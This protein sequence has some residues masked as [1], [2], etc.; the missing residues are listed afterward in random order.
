VGAESIV[1]H[2]DVGRLLPLALALPLGCTA[3]TDAGK[4]DDPADTGAGAC[5]LADVD[6]VGMFLHAIDGGASD[7]EREAIADFAESARALPG[8]WR[9]EIRLAYS[10]DA[11]EFTAVDGTVLEHAAVPEILRTDDGKYL[12]YYV[13]GDLDR[14]VSIADE[15][16]AWMTTHGIPG[17]G[18]LAMAT[19]DDGIHFERVEDFAIDALV[20]GM[21]VDPDV[22][23][24]P[25]GTWRMYY[26]G[27]TVQDLF[28]T[29]TWEYPEA[30]DV[31]WAS[32]TD[33][34]HWHQEAMVVSGPFADPSVFCSA[35]DA[36]VM[37]SFGLEWSRSTDGGVTFTHEGPWG[38][39]GFAP[40][41][42]R[43]EDGSARMFFNS[44]ALGAS[45]QSFYAADGETWSLEEGERMPGTYGEAVTLTRTDPSG[46][47][48]YFHT[49]TDPDDIPS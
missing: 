40:E 33:L 41:F 28:T 1:Y 10:E 18:A 30:H 49:F 48:L 15:G 29:Q 46:W 2:V 35:D 25:D 11:Q 44:R 22:V 9:Q 42:V 47:N 23:A 21:V 20:R 14:L 4:S 16:S 43:F 45:L 19:S 24:Q 5:T 17:I 13:D 34:V 37:A 7:C 6:E 26:V 32:S 38:V 12:L 39:D 31:Y 3:P 27:M 36:C 8:P